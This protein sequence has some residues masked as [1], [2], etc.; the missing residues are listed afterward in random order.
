MDR[1]ETIKSLLVGSVLGGV[2]LTTQSCREDLESVVP[3]TISSDS[4]YDYGRTPAEKKHDQ[5]I[6]DSE[7]FFSTDELA[8]L[9]VL[10]DII[11]PATAEFGGANDAEVPA[12]IAFIVKDMPY[13]QLPI[14]GGLMWLK[15]ES[16][17]R[18]GIPFTALSTDQQIEIIDEIAYP[19]TKFKSPELEPGR[20]FFRLMRNLTLTGYYT[21]RIGVDAL[22]YIG[23]RPNMWDGV[24]QDVLDQHGMTYEEEW[25]AKC[26][27]HETREQAAEWDDDG[28]LL[29]N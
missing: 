17:Q 22:G 11:L 20:T 25:L 26:I 14:Q 29:N 21:S 28:N 23:N 27:N 6:L 16:N 3:E 15:G 8:T 19:D 24:P 13:H 18:F 5:E 1:R 2:A 9:A 10:C 7:P 12:F 4:D